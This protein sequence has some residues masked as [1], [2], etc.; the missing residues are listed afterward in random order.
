M[1]WQEAGS[2]VPAGRGE[3][4][5]DL[6]APLRPDGGPRRVGCTLGRGNIKKASIFRVRHRQRFVYL[7][8]MLVYL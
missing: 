6:A 5:R 2:G 1:R 7:G 8:R 4:G 3:E